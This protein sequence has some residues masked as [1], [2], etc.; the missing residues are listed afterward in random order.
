MA[1]II[2]ARFHELPYDML[3]Q[4]CQNLSNDDLI[5]LIE[6]NKILAEAC[7]DILKN[8]KNYIFNVKI[9]KLKI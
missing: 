3:D 9:W 5:N 8:V 2:D 4:I 7:A 6:T 1:E